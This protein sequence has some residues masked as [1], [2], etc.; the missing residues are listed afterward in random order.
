VRR[1]C[2]SSGAPDGS[3]ATRCIV[4]LAALTFLG[5]SSL[6]SQISL[7]HVTSCGPVTLPGTNCTIPATGSG[8]LLVVGWQIG[9]GANT[10]TAIS[11]ITDNAG[12]AYAEAGAARAIDT[13]A[14][15]VA[16]IWYAANI[17][18]GATSI[19]VTPSSSVSNAGLVIWEF[20]GA[21]SSAPLDQTAVLNSQAA[22]ATPSAA[23]VG[24]AAANEIVISL[25][26]VANAVTGIASGNGFTNDSGL[27]GNGWAHMITSSPGSYFAQWNQSS[28]GT[29]ASCTVSFKAAIVTGPASACDLNADGVVNSADVQLVVDMSLG[30]MP[31]TADIV[32]SGIC[33]STVVQ[34]VVAAAI[35]GTCATSAIQHS[36]SLSWTLSASSNVAGYNVY[37]GTVSG[38]PYGTKLDA[39]LIIGSS[40]TDNSVVSGQTYYYVA[41]AVDS[42]GN[43]SSYSNQAT[44][45]IPTP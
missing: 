14:G 31:C 44:A 28:A 23:A 18:A 40:V 36:V 20:S 1:I 21:N 25:A 3:N 38:G 8:N 17:A 15:S 26:P 4:L 39:S 43:E 12:N 29:Y 19:A 11:S 34:D 35:G 2:Q 9:G 13:A 27:K 37:R 42:L 6:W 10:S 41:T 16:D 32:G 33:N 45:V 5:A 22:T 24:I 30:L 7:V